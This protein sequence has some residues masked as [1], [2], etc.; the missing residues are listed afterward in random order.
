MIT[1]LIAT[2]AFAGPTI[3]E[4]PQ[5][6]A[7]RIVV[8]VVVKVPELG[9]TELAMTR[10]ISEAIV[11]GTEDFTRGALTGYASLA[12]PPLRSWLQPDCIRI[13]FSV[14]AGQLKL[15]LSLVDSMV[16]RPQLTDSVDALLKEQPYRPHGYWWEALNPWQP[17]YGRIRKE[18]LQE[19]FARLFQP[20]NI[21]VAVGGELKPG[22]ADALFKTR[23]QDWKATPLRNRIQSKPPKPQ[24]TRRSPV[25]TAEFSGPPIKPIDVARTGMVL[26]ALGTG[27]G[28]SMFRSLR[29]EHGWTYR[30]EAVLWPD[31]RGFVPR[32]ITA[33]SPTDDDAKLA[34]AML[35]ALQKDVDLWDFQTVDRAY[36][37]AEGILTRDVPLSPFYFGPNV[38]FASSL[39][40]RTFMAAYW[41][42]KTG[43]PWNPDALLMEMRKVTVE[44]LKQTAKEL[45]ENVAVRVISGTR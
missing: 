30:A 3:V 17:N 38:P 32:L 5:P 33:F 4:L 42:M 8:D 14:P 18:D 35:A 15:A 27:K 2:A 31:P 37:M 12:G 6:G 39:E 22:E 26:I 11:Q 40:D 36:G 20:D 21:T 34:E 7:G 13:E 29:T 43:S 24:T 16:R 41:P 23:W 25:S 44:D 9:E 45:L 10:L 19:Q 1:A 28:S